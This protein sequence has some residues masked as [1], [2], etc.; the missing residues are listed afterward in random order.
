MTGMA[1]RGRLF[2]AAALACLAFVALTSAA[3]VSYPG[4]TYLDPATRGFSFFNNF[5]SDLGRTQ[6]RLGGP[7][8]LTRGL[9]TAALLAVS[10]GMAAFFAALAGLV[11]TAPWSRFLSRAGSLCGILAGA[12]FAGVAL[13]PSD[14]DLALH[15]RLVQWAFRFFLGAVLCY[16]GALR[17]EHGLPPR[18]RRT[19]VAFAVLLAAYVALITWGPSPR[20][21]GGQTLQAT[22][23]KIIV[24]ASVLCV[25][26]QAW[27][28][29]A[30]SPPPERP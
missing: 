15:D 21:P 13:V 24:L 5:F 12:C 1:W 26:A 9:F 18:F 25:G 23:Q 20:A 16:I 10:A 17:G 14:V 29:R 7:Q 27:W 6:T 2:T 11:R 28:A 8:D 3:I 22:G 19:F 30:I 4:G